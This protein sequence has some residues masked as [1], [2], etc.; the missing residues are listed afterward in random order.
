MDN[1]IE[2]QNKKIVERLQQR[3]DYENSADFYHCGNADCQKLTFEK[4]LDLSFKCP[5]CGKLVNLSKNDKLK[6]SLQAKI[7][8]LRGDLKH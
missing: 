4:A 6:K 3:L 8:E 5:T 1:F 7:D 2:N